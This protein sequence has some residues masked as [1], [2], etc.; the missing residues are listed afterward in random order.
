MPVLLHHL[1]LSTRSAQFK[2]AADYSPEFR[3]WDRRACE[4][5]ER[6]RPDCRRDVIFKEHASAF[7]GTPLVGHLIAHRVDTLLI[8]GCSTSACVRATATDAKSNCLKPI[9]VRE[10]V[11]DRSEVAHEWTL[12]DIQ[13][14]F[15]DVVGPDETLQYFQWSQCRVARTVGS[16]ASRKKV[17]RRRV[18]RQG[19][20]GG[21]ASGSPLPPPN[22]P[23]PAKTPTCLRSAR[24]EARHQR[25]GHV[26]R[27]GRLGRCRR[28]WSRRGS[29]ASK[30]F[31]DLSI[32]RQGRRRD[33]EAAR[34]G[35][36]PRDHRRGRGALPGHRGR[37][38][39]RRPQ[40][41][42][43][44]A[45]TRP[46]MKN[47]VIIQKTHH[48]CYDNQLTG[49][50][51]K[52]VRGRDRGRRG[53]GRQRPHRA[54]VLHE[55]HRTPT[56]R[57][58]ATSGSHSPASTRCRRCSTPRPTCRRSTSGRTAPE[59]GFD[60]VAFSGGKAMRGPERH[61]P[62]AR[63]QGPDRRG[64]GNANPNC[65]TI[66]R[67]M[68]VGKEDM[69]ALLAAVERFVKLDPD[70]E[71]KEFERRIAVIE[72]AVRASRRS[73]AS[74]SCRRSPTTSRHLQIAWD[75]NRVKITREK[76]TR[77]PPRARPRSASAA[78]RIGR[79]GH[80][81]FRALSTSRRRANCREPPAGIPQ[82]PRTEQ[83]ALWFNPGGLPL[84]DS[85]SPLT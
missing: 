65:G 53:E 42:R 51:A 61:R 30:H 9:I 5:D 60:L 81:D 54:D 85:Q 41:H 72:K 77:E 63:P 71:R 50:G 33:R 35:G 6:V 17:A 73:S 79:E 20:G 2:S 31:V 26:H 78:F 34:R 37:R 55:P 11:Q 70:S 66:G 69:V 74:G 68:K 16:D 18:P 24:R 38:H 23:C 58:N 15:A 3:K 29:E 75:E 12:F 19:N 67:M 22:R 43:G 28:R 80:S 84:P 76:L 32:A 56:G 36:R 62:P 1:A 52:L 27:A 44:S 59:M 7:A 57:S 64:E 48:S 8:T 4:I 46:G 14:R 47:E 40:A 25:G 21:L 39:P 49:V 45:R 13:A 10:A 83:T 82:K